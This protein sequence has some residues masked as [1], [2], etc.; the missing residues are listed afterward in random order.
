M[1]GSTVQRLQLL[2][3]ELVEKIPTE[4]FVINWSVFDVIQYET[5]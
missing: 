2:N 3:L 4:Q 1:E 5:G